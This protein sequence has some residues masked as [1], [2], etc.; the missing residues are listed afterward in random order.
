MKDFSSRYAPVKYRK[1]ARRQGD[2]GIEKYCRWFDSWGLWKWYP[3]EAKRDQAFD[4][5]I[6]HRNHDF[7]IRKV[8]R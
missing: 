3:T 1:A 7:K 5:L 8:E 4:M 6:K 2:W